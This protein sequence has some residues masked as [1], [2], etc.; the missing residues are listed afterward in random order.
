V[1]YKA[2]DGG[3]CVAFLRD[4]TERKR[5]EQELARAVHE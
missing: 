4:I 3:R 5:A 1:Q 2:L